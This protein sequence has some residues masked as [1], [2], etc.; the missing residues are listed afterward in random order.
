MVSFIIPIYNVESLLPR[1]IES[2]I[3]QTYRDLEIIL[4]DDGS[5]DK[6]GTICDDYAKKDKRIKV[7]HKQNGGIG[8]AR[9]AGIKNVSGDYISFVD[10]DDY[11]MPQ[12]VDTL[13]GKM[14][15]QQF[16][17]AIGGFR[18][19]PLKNIIA[20][21]EESHC[22]ADIPKFLKN[23][24][25][26]IH[27]A[28][29][30]SKIY[31][32]Q[33]IKEHN[34]LFDVKTRF[35]EDLLF[36]MDYLCWCESV[37]LISNTDYIYTDGNLLTSEK[38]AQ[39][40]QELDYLL[41]AC[42]TRLLHLDKRYNIEIDRYL[43]RHIVGC[44]R[45]ENIYSQKSDEEYYHLYKIYT[46]IQDKSSFYDDDFCSPIKRSIYKVAQCYREHKVEK[47][48]VLI[49]DMQALYKDIDYKH[50]QMHPFFKLLLI[51][52]VKHYNFMTKMLLQAYLIYK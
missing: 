51:S 24:I 16:D 43:L 22:K 30:S 6:S 29:I 47:G 39:D 42:E 12:Y 33:I 49:H 36:N 8:S 48:E 13:L 31:K 28:M 20:L 44:Y 27:F 32:T 7:I 35:A 52:I 14:L 10:A 26:G 11:V 5:N 19:F 3:G 9:N 4:V 21:T 1:C 38:Y 2:I 41:N 45:L 50:I 25:A 40:Y 46:R 18:S 15:S 37:K 23:N 17:F 34:L